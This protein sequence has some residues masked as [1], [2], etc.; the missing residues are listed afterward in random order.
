MKMKKGLVLAVGLFLISASLTF[1]SE[2]KAPSVAFTLASTSGDPTPVSLT[3]GL[4]SSEPSILAGLGGSGYLEDNVLRN[5]SLGWE[6][7]FNNS[8]WDNTAIG[9]HALYSN[10]TGLMNT[11]VGSGAL[12]SN[13]LGCSN[14]AIGMGALAA[15]LYSY[16][17]TAV[18]EG[19]LYRS[20]EGM[21]NTAIG[22][23][24]LDF[25]TYGWDNIAVG[26][27]AGT[28]CI[29]ATGNV[30][31]GAHVT[32]VVGDSHTIRIGLPY[33]ELAPMHDG[34]AG[35]NR[36]FIAGIVESPLLPGAAPSVV[37]ITSEGRLGT[38][39]T[40]LLPKGDTGPQGPQGI[41]G[42][43]GEGLISGSLLFLLRGVTPPTGYALLGTSEFSLMA[44][45]SKKA[46]KLIVNIYQKQ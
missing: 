29:N 16:G 3:L 14:T 40:E 6:T 43:G 28:A 30:F 26:N 4:R 34:P 45:G 32:G 19:A 23:G 36:T 24:A 12:S 13:I 9:Y 11:A 33:D 21:D 44:P 46:T 38:F 31:L 5:T 25:L 7:L 42:P 18:G 15:N 22:Y 2:A 20:V 27:S 35:Q 39:P 10:T 8:G 1:A 41:Q 37:G 17:N